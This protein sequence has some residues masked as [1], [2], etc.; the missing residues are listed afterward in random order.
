YGGEEFCLMLPETE[1]GSTGV[2]AERIRRRVESTAVESEKGPTI[3]VTA[4]IGMA[5]FNSNSDQAILGANALIER[6]DQ[7]LYRAKDR[8]RNRVETWDLAPPS[9][10]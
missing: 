6:A 9:D 8:G 3:R 5:G 2:V 10:H 4:S 1:I 7:A